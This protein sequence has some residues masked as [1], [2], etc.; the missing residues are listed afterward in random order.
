MRNW[1]VLIIIMMGLLCVCTRANP[2][3]LPNIVVIISDDQGY[4]D[5]GFM[6]HPVIQT[7][8]LDQLAS[9]SLLC[10]VLRW[11]P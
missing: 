7:P 3:S 10:A 1:L 6:D 4:E 2:E 9:E 11:P 5:Y 8:H